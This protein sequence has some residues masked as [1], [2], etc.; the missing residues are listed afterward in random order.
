MILGLSFACCKTAT[1]IFHW[2]LHK[3]GVEILIRKKWQF[4]TSSTALHCVK[5]TAGAVY[6]V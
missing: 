5:I 1:V 2:E 4:L 6:Q 3:Y